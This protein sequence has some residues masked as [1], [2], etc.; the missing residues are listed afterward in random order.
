MFDATTR[1]QYKAMVNEAIDAG[2]SLDRAR[3]FFRWA[4]LMLTRTRI[5]ASNGATIPVRRSALLNFTIRARNRLLANLTP[6]SREKWSIVLRP[7][8]L[9]DTPKILDLIDRRLDAFHDDAGQPVPGATE[10]EEL[11]AVRLQLRRIARLI[12]HF[13]GRKVARLEAL[14]AGPADG[15]GVHVVFPDNGT[16]K[17]A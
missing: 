14:L 6:W 11:A 16:R 17:V 15:V 10:A 9:S 13:R 5:D 8:H 4:V 1:V 12:E 7:R 2:W 3:E